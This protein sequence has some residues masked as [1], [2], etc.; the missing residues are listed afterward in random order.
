M[1]GFGPNAHVDASKAF[2]MPGRYVND[3]FD[4]TAQRALRRTPSRRAPRASSRCAILKRASEIFAGA[5]RSHWSARASMLT[6][7]PSFFTGR[8]RATLLWLLWGPRFN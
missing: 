2:A 5:G 1:G 4:P 8:W 7:G 6:E 3:S